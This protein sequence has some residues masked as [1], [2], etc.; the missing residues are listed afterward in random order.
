MNKVAATFSFT[1]LLGIIG[2]YLGAAINLEGILGVVLA[3]ATTG[4]FIVS[5]IGD[6]KQK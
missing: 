3:I 1:L 4:A 5:A 2:I 6:L